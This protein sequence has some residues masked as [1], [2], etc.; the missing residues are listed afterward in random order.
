MSRVSTSELVIFFL[1]RKQRRFF[2]SLR[3][4]CLDFCCYC[5][6]CFYW[7]F[8]SRKAFFPFYY[9]NIFQISIKEYGI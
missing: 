4:S 5:C 8:L 6:F 3:A 9:L 1:V 2:W 7:F